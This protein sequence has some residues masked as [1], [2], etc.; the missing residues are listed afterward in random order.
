[1]AASGSPWELVVRYWI[2]CA[3]LRFKGMM[4]NATSVE[5]GVRDRRIVPGDESS[6]PGGALCQVSLSGGNAPLTNGNAE[7]VLKHRTPATALNIEEAIIMACCSKDCGAHDKTLKERPVTS[8]YFIE[9]AS[10]PGGK[11]SEN[12]GSECSFHQYKRR[13]GLAYNCFTGI[14]T[15]KGTG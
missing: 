2:W 3:D 4:P 10:P 8:I 1:M 14:A 12:Y 7:T 5:G 9:N 13:L 15:N 11:S 6:K